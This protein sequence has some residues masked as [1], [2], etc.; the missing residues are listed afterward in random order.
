MIIIISKIV[1]RYFGSFHGTLLSDPPHSFA[2]DPLALP[3]RALLLVVE[4]SKAV[5]LA[6]LPGAYV[7]VAVLP[8]ESA[9][10][11]F[12]TV[13]ELA[14]VYSTVRPGF[15]SSAFHV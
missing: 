7:F 1:F 12:L 3:L 10:P 8:E 14:L 5:L 9:F 2:L 13:Y 6:L 4:Y 11:V 15:F